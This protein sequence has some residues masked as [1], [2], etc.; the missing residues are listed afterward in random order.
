[1][2]SLLFLKIKISST[3]ACINSNIWNKSFIFCCIM[4]GELEIP[5][6]KSLQQYFPQGRMIIHKLLFLLIGNYPM[7]K[8]SNVAYWKPSN[9]DNISLIFDIRYGLWF[10]CL[11]GYLKSL[12]KCTWFDL[13]LGCAKDGYHHSES[14]ARSSTHNR[15]KHST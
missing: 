2:S 11:F 9:F 10:N 14:L 5:I 12:R 3:Y 4:S 13:G 15:N 1:M 6:G 7:F 8:S